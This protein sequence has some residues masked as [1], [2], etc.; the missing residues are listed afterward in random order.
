MNIRL[1]IF[2]K[3]SDSGL[4]TYKNR[5]LEGGGIPSRGNCRGGGYYGGIVYFYYKK[6][7]KKEHITMY[8]RYITFQKSQTMNILFIQK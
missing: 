8:Y 5:K 1:I 7:K 4:Q 3:K 6:T 2:L